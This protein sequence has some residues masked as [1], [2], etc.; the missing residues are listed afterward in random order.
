VVPL[1]L[2]TDAQAVV[3]ANE[4]DGVVHVGAALAPPDVST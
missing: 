4:A 1:V 2:A 3:E